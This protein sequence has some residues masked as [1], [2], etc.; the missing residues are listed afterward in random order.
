MANNV[1]TIKEYI[2]SFYFGIT[3]EVD[4]THKVDEKVKKKLNKKEITVFKDNTL[5][6]RKEPI[7]IQKYLERPLLYQHRKFDIRVW[8]L[9]KHLGD[10]YIFRYL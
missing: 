8:V 2:K 1:E 7:I 9:F 5:K 6:Y 4:T 10:Y 3:N